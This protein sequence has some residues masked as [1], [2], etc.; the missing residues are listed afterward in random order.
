MEVKLPD[1]C[2]LQATVVVLAVDDALTNV[3]L[4]GAVNQEDN[5][6]TL[7]RS[8]HAYLVKIVF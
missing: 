8:W 7:Y 5:L 2:A 1:R 3:E 6:S 4:D